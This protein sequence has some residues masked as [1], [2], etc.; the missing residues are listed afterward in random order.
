MAAEPLS[1]GAPDA[2]GGHQTSLL[3]AIPPGACLTMDELAGALPDLNRRQLSNAA[4]GLALRGLVERVERG[5]FRLTDGGETAQGAGLVI[6]SGP[7]GPMPRKRATRNSLT[8]RLWRAMRLKR[9]FTIPDLLELA[10]RDE[11]YPRNMAERLVR[12]LA[13]AGYLHGLGTR[14]KGTSPTSNGFRRWTLIR[15]T[16]PL[17]PIRRGDGTLYDP[18][19][20]ETIVLGWT[21]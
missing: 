5:C 15:D 18:N 17:P 21:P 16:G 2:P 11:K 7:R 8:S 9:K 10:A 14:Q 19:T 12:A 3:N 13:D 20:G 4:T 1:S 6:K